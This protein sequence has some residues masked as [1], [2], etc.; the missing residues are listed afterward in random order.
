M[1]GESV[2][3]SESTGS[4]EYIPTQIDFDAIMD[5]EKSKRKVVMFLI[6][7]RTQFR[8]EVNYMIREM[9]LVI[10]KREA[11]INQINR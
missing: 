7:S 8:Q 3:M 9:G 2:T 10:D 4:D 6:N 1:M 5:M 11:T